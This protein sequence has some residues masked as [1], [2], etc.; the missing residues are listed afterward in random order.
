MATAG[1]AKTLGLKV[2]QFSAGYQFD[3]I[4]VDANVE[5]TNLHVRGDSNTAQ[6]MLQKIIYCAE[7]RNIS[8]VWVQGR[9]VKGLA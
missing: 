4:V 1:G 8:N 9:M 5:D 3:A 2:G 6:D 7:R